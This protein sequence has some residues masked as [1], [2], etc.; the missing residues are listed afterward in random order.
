[1]TTEQ[2]AT[3]QDDAVLS[4]QEQMDV[5]Q[6]K[7]KAA[8]SAQAEEIADVLLKRRDAVILSVKDLNDLLDPESEA[9]ELIGNAECIGMSITLTAGDEGEPPTITRSLINKSA[10]KAAK[11]SGGATGN[12][13]DLEGDFR[14]V[15]SPEQI[16]W[17]EAHKAD[18]KEQ[19]RGVR[20]GFMDRVTKNDDPKSVNVPASK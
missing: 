15:A 11:K 17:L 16:E 2:I 7:M 6:E 14:A 1:M 13:R 20:W 10:P 8:K 19:G 3:T 4:L 12:R 5:I 18:N 9:W